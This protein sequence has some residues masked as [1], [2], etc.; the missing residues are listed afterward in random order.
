MVLDGVRL[1]EIMGND[2]LK[3]INMQFLQKNIPG[4]DVPEVCGK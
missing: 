2:E 3:H 4:S 1:M